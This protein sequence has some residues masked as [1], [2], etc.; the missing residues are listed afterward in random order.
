MLCTEN[1]PEVDLDSYIIYD[2]AICGNVMSGRSPHIE[3]TAPTK[4]LKS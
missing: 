1:K 4:M 3:K 2:E